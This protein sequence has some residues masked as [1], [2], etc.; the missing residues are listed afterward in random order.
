MQELTTNEI[1]EALGKA[2]GIMT[3]AVFGLALLMIV[4]AFV[5]YG[6]ICYLKGLYKAKIKLYKLESRCVGCGKKFYHALGGSRFCNNAPGEK[7]GVCSSCHSFA[8]SKQIRKEDWSENRM[9]EIKVNFSM[10]VDCLG[11]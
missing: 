9:D 8:N 10:L 1:V 11:K 4:M 5:C 6:V 3:G 2:I 7:D